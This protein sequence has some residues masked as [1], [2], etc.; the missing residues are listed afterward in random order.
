MK[1]AI[2]LVVLGSWGQLAWA[3]SMPTSQPS[4]EAKLVT[5][6]YGARIAAAL[7]APDPAGKIGL[8]QELLDAAGDASSPATLRRLLAAEVIKL[9][10]GIGTDEATRL[11][12][13]AVNV[14]FKA[15]G[16]TALEKARAEQQ[17]AQAH[18]DHT[19]K[20]DP[21]S[22]PAVMETLIKA[23]VSLAKAMMADDKAEG[24]L[25]ILT[26]TAAKAKG[27][28]IDRYD[29]EI[30][31][32]QRDARSCISRLARV[33]A[34]Q[35]QLRQAQDSGDPAAVKTATIS[36][37][38][39][40][41]TAFG[42]LEKAQSCL[43]GSGHEYEKAVSLALS[44]KNRKTTRMPADDLDQLDVLQKIAAAGENAPARAALGQPGVG[45]CKSFLTGAPG[46]LAATKVRLLMVQF[47][48]LCGESAADK[49]LK[50]IDANYKGLGAKLA[51]L[52]NGNLQAT[53]D[54]T[55]KK[56]V[57]DFVVTDGTWDIIAGQ[58]SLGAE[59][60]RGGT[61]LAGNRLRFKADQ[62]LTVSFKASGKD[63][64]EATLGFWVRTTYGYSQSHNVDLVFGGNNNRESWLRD[65]G[66]TVWNDQR[67]R[68]TG[69]TFKIDI[70]WDG[71]GSITWTINGKQLCKQDLRFKPDS[72]AGGCVQLR[73]R[74]MGQ[75]MAVDDLV[76]E[77]VVIE[78]PSTTAENNRYPAPAP[79][80]MKSK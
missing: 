29:E 63:H 45:L 17:I 16:M 24:A 64:I 2:T 75:P 71:K 40:Y 43:A 30:A 36:L 35:T 57:G 19:R 11:A 53:Y 28:R 42:D 69:G 27:A 51:I 41:L 26:A 46:G 6:L 37:G 65:D 59:P 31:E 33:Q 60:Q 66:N 76:I 72:L 5:S 18:V 8:G 4:A 78:D 56:Q 10:T 34:A 9:T 48:K 68:L 20:T 55:G 47:E 13:D 49:L 3:Q 77:G 58:H 50:K 74:T 14:A 22:L 70:A 54:F 80:S 25:A 61:A 44:F 52:S 7:N 1:L 39:L 15:G 23:E 62:P 32:L 79:T 12:N 21:P 73:L 38:L 67:A